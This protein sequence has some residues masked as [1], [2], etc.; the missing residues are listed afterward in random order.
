MVL[1]WGNTPAQAMGCHGMPW[2]AMGFKVAVSQ[3]SGTLGYYHSKIA[4]MDSMD[5]QSSAIFLV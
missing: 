5:V 2:D 3:K 4:F 1:R